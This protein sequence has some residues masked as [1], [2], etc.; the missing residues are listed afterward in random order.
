MNTGQGGHLV[1]VGCTTTVVRLV[2]ELQRA[3]ERVVV[4]IGGDPEGW[5]LA[6]LTDVASEVV[7]T[8]VVR[9]AAL[10]EAGV[11]T[12]RAVAILG[13]GDV[14]ALRLAL[15]VE[16]VH[17]GAHIVLEM[18]RSVI[19]HR[20]TELLGDCEVLS[21][22]QLAAPSFVAA[23][24]ASGS[25]ESFEIGGRQVVAGSRGRV[26]GTTLAVLG[27][28][29]AVTS[30]GLLGGEGDVLLGTEVIPAGRPQAR[31]SGF[32]GALA[33]IIDARARA[34]L[35]VLL[36]LI[37]AST[38]FFRFVGGLDW[39]MAVY[40]ALTAS[41]LTG[42]GDVGDLSLSARFGA[43]SIQLAGLVLSSG[44]TAVIVDAMISA[45]LSDLAGG[46][47]GRPK[48]HVVVCGLGR[49]GTAVALM[50]KNSGVPV[51][52][53]E[54]T[55]D[56]VGVEEARRARI[57]VVV[58]DATHPAAL[59][60]AGIQRAAAVLAVTDADAANL[61]ISM[62]ARDTRPDVRVV[63][64][65]FDHELAARVEQR[66]HLGVTRSVS[67]VAAPVVAAALLGHR[68][69]HIVSVGRRVLVL[70]EVEV[71]PGSEAAGLLAR[72]L[73]MAH[74]LRVL[75]VRPHGGE[76]AWQRT[77]RAL[78]VGDT[79][80]VAASRRGQSRLWRLVGSATDAS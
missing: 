72:D 7:R 66:L 20:L 61:E 59:Q 5:V 57:P 43:V 32:W 9:E 3:G 71:E 65:L 35:L 49:V 69:E 46:V 62:V 67:M 48:N 25:V 6:D 77:D 55:A 40:A 47:R 80:A 17:P 12:A 70:G 29:S 33:Q 58:A 21:T 1:V 15:L 75:A 45:R 23:T 30:D 11:G 42:I 74:E 79:L 41:T 73:E 34:V 37:I 78:A 28:S 27:D 22:A 39:I 16:E 26:G 8:H 64:R 38:L 4:V 2:D 13:Q 50:L 19:S 56:A 54:R 31:Q 14:E 18:Q 51:V 53:L 52:A 10:R 63:T 36:A 60:H 24:L 44:L 68:V 76:W